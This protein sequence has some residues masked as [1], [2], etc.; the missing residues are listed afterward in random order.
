M[1]TR[2]DKVKF[3]PWAVVTG[4]SSGI[5]KEFARQLAA[6]G[7]NVV[8][9]A[10]RLALLESLGQQLAT[11]FAVSY[12]A[13]GLDLSDTDFLPQLAQVTHDLDVGLVVSNAGTGHPGE[14]LSIDP[15]IL[16]EVA[17]LNILAHL[18]LARHYGPLLA[19]RGRGGL[20]LVSA[21]GAAQGI[22]YMAND[23][24]TK[25]YV[26]TLGETLNVEFKKHGVNV[27]VLLP[28]PTE[29][30]V[31]AILGF[32]ADRMPMRPMTVEQ[33]VSEALTALKANRPS[34][35]TGTLF[36]IMS[37]LMPRKLFR[38]VNGAMIKRALD[39]KRA[40]MADAR[41]VGNG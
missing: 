32:D 26:L 34:H 31:F 5:G 1:I 14:F 29:T 8:L 19:Q 39:G 28:G 37:S 4:A 15:G 21:M 24:A 6:N 3:G 18:S 10:R 12:R 7:I 16:H 9:V 40:R 36:R 35:I 30:P 20:L 2:I 33:C 17:R 27:T 25:A 41:E 22:P 23:S 13:V 38:T 11:E